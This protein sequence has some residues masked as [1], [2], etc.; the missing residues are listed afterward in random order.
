[1]AEMPFDLDV[2]Y[3]TDRRS[4]GKYCDRLVGQ[5]ASFSAMHCSQC[6]DALNG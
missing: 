4:E 3:E 1:M 5:C 2:H 6:V